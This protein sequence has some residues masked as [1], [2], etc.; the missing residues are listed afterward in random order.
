M[1]SDVILGDKLYII[2]NFSVQSA[3]IACEGTTETM[4]ITAA[5]DGGKS[6]FSARAKQLAAAYDAQTPA[7]KATPKRS[8][9]LKKAA[10]DKTEEV[11]P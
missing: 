7:V 5:L 3:G 4:S 1:S 11:L 9:V 10:T 6:E 8:A 2:T